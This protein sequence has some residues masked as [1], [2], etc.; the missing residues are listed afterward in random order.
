MFLGANMSYGV[1]KLKKNDLEFLIES[2]V[3]GQLESQSFHFIK[4]SD[5]PS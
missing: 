4:I 3:S 1:K 5:Y 2:M